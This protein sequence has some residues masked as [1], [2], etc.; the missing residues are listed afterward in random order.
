MLLGNSFIYGFLR[1]SIIISS[2]DGGSEC[3]TGH[4]CEITQPGP[5]WTCGDIVG[6]VLVLTHAMGVLFQPSSILM[7]F[8]SFSVYRKR[9]GHSFIPS[10]WPSAPSG[11]LRCSVRAPRLLSCRTVSALGPGACCFSG[12]AMLTPWVNWSSEIPPHAQDCIASE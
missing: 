7:Y 3:L 4:V 9:A 1:L 8:P 11:G 2:S 10:S 12:L 5:D 6:I